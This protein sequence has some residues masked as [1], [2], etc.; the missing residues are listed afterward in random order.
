MIVK[1][2][3]ASSS[4]FNGVKYNDKK[5]E[6]G[7][8]ERMLM[9]NFPSFI[10]ENSSKEQVRN[11]LKSIS[12][13]DRIK[14]PQFHAVISTKFQ[15]HSKEELTK[16]AG[17]FMLEMGY[18]KQPFI[19]VFHSDTDH[20]HI[21]I[22]SSRV[23]KQTGKKIND[24]YERLKAQKA[25]INAT[26]KL[27]GIKE[28]TELDKL[29]KYQIS[30]L[31][32]LELL[33]TRNGFK[34]KKDTN[35]EKALDILKNGVK[36]KTIDGNQIS[37][38]PY[39]K[40]NR[41]KQLKAILNKYKEIYSNKV[42][43]IEDNRAHKGLFRTPQ[44]FKNPKVTYESEVQKKLKDIFGL[45]LVFHNKGDASPFGY[46]IIDHKSRKVIK[47][48]DVLKMNE[49]FEFT[50]DK[51]DK[52]TFELLKDYNV[53]DQNSKKILLRYFNENNQKINIQDFMLFENKV[54][55]DLV[56]YRKVQSEV[57]AFIKNE[58]K[59]EN[60]KIIKTEDSLFY[61]LHTKFHYVSELEKLFGVKDF[62]E[63]L[64]P[65][66]QA[67]QNE[68]QSKNKVSKFVEQLLFELSKTSV[69][70]KDSA[71]EERKKKRKKK[72]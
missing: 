28:E 27:Y 5:I 16:I 37:F 29:L 20:N 10:N 56:I 26:E 71:E 62:K 49:L 63:F 58:N 72:K 67:K 14:N 48:S 69:I 31:H 41:N 6:K 17:E 59:N 25:L 36:L 45:D 3:N 53:P 57:R 70:G 19:A 24:S 32:Q 42:F 11:Y 33:L 54:R 12:K 22:V 34:L 55:K 35:D 13:N 40:D 18:G 2:L 4:D 38:T 44:N 39:S 43:A 30:S 68:N 15:E 47:G 61:A 52:K 21:H 9:K 8:G 60:V 66:I 50:H 23:S 7:S 64:N 1:I 51:I 46:S 65:D